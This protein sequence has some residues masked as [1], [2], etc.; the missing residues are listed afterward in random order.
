MKRCVPWFIILFCLRSDG[1]Y[2]QFSGMDQSTIDAMLSQQGLSCQYI[3][4]NDYNVAISSQAA[5][6]QAAQN[7]QQV[8]NAPY[9][10]ELSTTGVAVAALG[11]GYVAANAITQINYNAKMVRIIQLKNI[12][13]IQ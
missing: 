9:I 10:L 7:A 2:L 12:L 5:T 8:A 6:R 11:N 13:G 1:A 4:A 3:T